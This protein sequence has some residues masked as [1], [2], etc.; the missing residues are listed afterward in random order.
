MNKERGAKDRNR[1]R[2]SQACRRCRAKRNKCDGSRPACSACLTSGHDCAYDVRLRKRGLREGYVR[3]LEKMLA[4]AIRELNGFEDDALALIGVMPESVA[5]QNQ[6]SAPWTDAESSNKLYQ[7]WKASRLHRALEGTLSY[8]ETVPP[9]GTFAHGKPQID[10]VMVSSMNQSQ[11]YMEVDQGL[12]FD[13]VR[14]E[15]P[16]ALSELPYAATRTNSQSGNTSSPC[17]PPLPPN[18][19]RLLQTYYATTHSWFPIIPKDEITRTLHLYSEQAYFQAGRS[20]SCAYESTLWAILSHSTCAASV[21]QPGESSQLLSEA[22]RY[23]FISRRLIPNRTEHC[24]L[25]HLEAILLLVLVNIEVEQWLAA[26]LLI[27]RAVKTVMSL[28]LDEPYDSQWSV[29]IQEGRTVAF[30][31]FVIDS[32]LA[33][34]RREPPHMP[35]EYLDGVALREEDEWTSWPAL[36]LPYQKVVSTNSPPSAPLHSFSCFQKLV[37]LARMANRMAGGVGHS[38]LSL[39]TFVYE[40]SQWESQIP[41]ECRLIGPDSIYPERHPDVLSHQIY[42]TLGYIAIL[43][44]LY[45]EITIQELSVTQ[46][47]VQA[48]ERA[49]KLL[50]RVTHVFSHHASQFCV[51]ELSTISMIS[52]KIILDR[53]RLLHE[54]QPGTFP[55]QKW[56]ESLRCTCTSPCPASPRFCSLKA[57]LS[58]LLCYLK[59]KKEKILIVIV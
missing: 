44:S 43:L 6:F 24:G 46:V 20:T 42:L 30:G 35:A 15:Q 11:D 5:L 29:M 40:L 19:T 9:P 32:F 7:S 16:D 55:Y 13:S 28:G 14:M 21:R 50:C 48:R 39:Q 58:R 25:G 41:R 57:D 49:K 23:Y 3:S 31:C 2:V 26:W 12:S 27:G 33:F 59:E 1:S 4:L 22:K 51:C 47:G 54:T 56:M 52:L 38:S 36:V 37:E 34:W 18:A 17:L 53:A 10:E 8:P 45:V